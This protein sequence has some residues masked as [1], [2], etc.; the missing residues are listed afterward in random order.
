M[1]TT[2]FQDLR[3]RGHRWQICRAKR[4]SP[5]PTCPDYRS[6]DHEI[7]TLSTASGPTHALPCEN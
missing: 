5:G 2:F 4:N 6:T 7:P 3:A 1:E